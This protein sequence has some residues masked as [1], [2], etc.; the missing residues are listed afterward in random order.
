M[1][2]KAYVDLCKDV[3]VNKKIVAYILNPNMKKGELIKYIADKKNVEYSVFVD[4]GM[5]ARVISEA[6]DLEFY[7]DVKNENWLKIL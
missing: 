3:H 6:W 4:R 1:R 2:K 7:H 5:D